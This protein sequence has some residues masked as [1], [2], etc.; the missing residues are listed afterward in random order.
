MKLFLEV[1]NYCELK[2]RFCIA[3][4]NHLYNATNLEYD[5]VKELMEKYKDEKHKAAFITG[6]EPL[7]HPRINEIISLLKSGGY[8]IYITTNGLHFANPDFLVDILMRGVDR[9]AIPIYGS[10]ARFHDEM[11]GVKGSFDQ[12]MTALDN[13]FY[14][15]RKYKL[16]TLIELRLLMS[17]FTCQDNVSIVNLVSKKYPDVDYLA[18]SGLQLSSQTTNYESMIELSLTEAES[19]LRKTIDAI[20]NSNIKSMVTGIPIC[21][22]GEK[23]EKLYG[24]DKLNDTKEKMSMFPHLSVGPYMRDFKETRFRK[25]S[26][27]QKSPLCNLCKYFKV[28]DGLQ[29]RYVERYGFEDLKPILEAGKNV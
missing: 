15:K 24:Y 5:F 1:N 27:K 17:R 3:D 14:I 7:L 18:L 12:L 9:I 19:Y 13:L 16:N 6:G 26:S 20:W 21:I 2:C 29:G 4:N 23:Y 10:E 22:M 11:T 28:C 25:E 8:Y